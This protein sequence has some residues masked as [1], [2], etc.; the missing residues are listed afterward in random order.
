MNVYSGM[1]CRVDVGLLLLGGLL[2]LTTCLGRIHCKICLLYR[3]TSV[4]IHLAT[5]TRL[6]ATAGA[7]T[8]AYGGVVTE[9]TSRGAGRRRA[10]KREVLALAER[11]N[12][13]IGT[14]RHLALLVG[15]LRHLQHVAEAL[16]LVGLHCRLNVRK[17]LVRHFVYSARSYCNPTGFSTNP[18]ATPAP[19]KRSHWHPYAVAIRGSSVSLPKLGSG[20]TIE[21]A[22]RL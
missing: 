16:S 21:I 1:P 20:A 10:G 9:H 12:V 7:T 22:L 15:L 3:L 18:G 8:A 4:L 6:A 11:L 2:E 13:A 19:E 5:A 17:P 14:T